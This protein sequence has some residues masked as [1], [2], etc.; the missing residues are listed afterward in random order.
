MVFWCFSGLLCPTIYILK[1]TSADNQ[2]L[3]LNV[4][5]I[6]QSSIQRF[7]P[8]GLEASVTMLPSKTLQAC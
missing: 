8:G 7:W 1:Q 4:S 2:S 5:Q 6:A 3:P